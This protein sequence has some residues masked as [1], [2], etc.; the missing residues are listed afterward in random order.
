MKVKLID[1]TSDA[2]ALLLYTKNTRLQGGVN[3]AG[4]QQWPYEKKM[5]H[6]AYMKDT[7]KSSWE[8][9]N[10]TFEISGVTRAFTHQLV[11]TRNGRYA[12]ES[13]R[14]VDVSDAEVK[15]PNFAEGDRS[16]YDARRETWHNA[17]DEVMGAYA[18]L[19]NEHGVA[20]QDARGILPTNVC[21]SIIAQFSLRTLHEMA[22]VRLCTRTQGEY[23]DVFRAM[24]AEVVRVHNW[25]EE[26]IQVACVNTGVCVF[27]RYTECPIQK[28]THNGLANKVNHEGVIREVKIAF[29]HI[30]H[31]AVPVAKDGR[32]M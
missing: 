11:R 13:M 26:F 31:E 1:H 14:T 24:K 19:V 16:N 32:T 17:E 9:V 8:F 20:P 29:E 15:R 2:L 6:L 12:Q 5:E 27:P 10:Y 30:R 7:I 3:L 22:N 28:W 25:A 18:T 21:T 23:Q 4:I